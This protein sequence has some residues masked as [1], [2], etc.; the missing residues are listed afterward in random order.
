MDTLLD[1]VQVHDAGEW[2]VLMG[3]EESTILSVLE[4]VREEGALDIQWPVKIG[5]RW[6]ASFLNPEA[7]PK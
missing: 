7:G 2:I 6:V 1:R 5:R 3:A 4:R